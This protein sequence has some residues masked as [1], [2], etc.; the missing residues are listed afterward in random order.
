MCTKNLYV[1]EPESKPPTFYLAVGNGEVGD[2]I[3]ASHGEATV[4]FGNG[5]RI[6]YRTGVDGSEEGGRVRGFEVLTPAYAVTVHKF[7]GSE[8]AKVVVAFFT[9]KLDFATRNL[10]YTAITRAKEWA[11]VVS[12]RPQ[13]AAAAQWAKTGNSRLAERVRELVQ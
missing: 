9:W 13:L 12:S 1:R 7:Q 6:V 10:L 8:A 4:L 2:V 3:E 5:E 11:V